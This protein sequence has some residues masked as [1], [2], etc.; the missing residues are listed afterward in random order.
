MDVRL[1]NGTVIKNVPE[2]TTKAQLIEKLRASNYDVSGLE[3]AVKPEVTGEVGFLEKASKATGIGAIPEGGFAETPSGRALGYIGE[4]IG[5]IP[6]SAVGFAGQAADLATLP[7]DPERRAQIL[8]ALGEAVAGAPMAIHK[9]IMR[10]VSSPRQTAQHV[11]H[12]RQYR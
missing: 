6:E 3:Q 8:P 10:A 2:G 5:N 11:L 7:F 4:T 9:G 12:P 1:P